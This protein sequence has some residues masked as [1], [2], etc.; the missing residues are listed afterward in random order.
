MHHPQH[1]K[2]WTCNIEDQQSTT[3]FLVKA[4]KPPQPNQKDSGQQP[5]NPSRQSDLNEL[6]QKLERVCHRL[7]RCHPRSFSLITQIGISKPRAVLRLIEMNWHYREAQYHNTN[8]SKKQYPS[9]HL[10]ILLCVRGEP[11]SH[12][13]PQMLRRRPMPALEPFDYISQPRS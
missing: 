7:S 11:R 13:S 6:W 4:S 9:A 3:G 10:K 1:K 2:Q 5:R 8:K 12:N